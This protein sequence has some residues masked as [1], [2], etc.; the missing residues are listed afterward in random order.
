MPRRE[1]RDR[2]SD[3]SAFREAVRDV[4]PIPESGR[5]M[6]EK[7]RPK[8]VPAQTLRDEA[9]VLRDSLSD[10]IPWHEAEETGEELCFLRESLPRMTLRRLRRGH[11]VIQAELDLHGLR[12]DEARLALTAFLNDCHRRGL[13]CLRV[14]HGKGLG[15][16]RREPV[17]KQK[18]R[19]WLMQREEV[20]AFC[21]APPF[22]GGAG[23]A[24]VLL[25][26]PHRRPGY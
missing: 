26:S 5:A 1:A 8:P 16:K 2:K 11:W 15:S 21:Q 20:L 4:I 23:A 13:R 7:P 19:V 25:K 22:E 12:S 17:L 14:I 24:L 18:V 6:P 9:Q 10:H 3:R